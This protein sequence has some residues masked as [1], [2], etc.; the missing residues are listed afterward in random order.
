MRLKS[1]LEAALGIQFINRL[2]SDIV[3]IKH[4]E[5]KGFVEISDEDLEFKQSELRSA[6][7]SKLARK[8]QERDGLRA[9]LDGFKAQLEEAKKRFEATFHCRA[10]VARDRCVSR[11]RS[12]SWRPT[13]TRRWRTKLVP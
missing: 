11:K 8:H 4:E 9:E 13:G 2:A 5:R 12:G 1:S 6:R 7:R 3:Y 10:R